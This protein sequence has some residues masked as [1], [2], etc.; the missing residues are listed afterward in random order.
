MNIQGRLQKFHFFIFLQ[1]KTFTSTQHNLKLFPILSY[2]RYFSNSNENIDHNNNFKT[3]SKLYDGHIPTHFFTKIGLAIG[4]GVIGLMNPKRDDM[5]SVLGETTGHLALKNM[6]NKMKQNDIGR[7]ILQ[8]KPLINSQTLDLNYLRNLPSNTFGKAYIEYMDSHGFNMHDRKPV[9]FVDDAELSYIMTRYRQVH[10]FLHPLSG[11]PP[12]V[13][14]ELV[15]KWY[16]LIQT[17]LPMTLFSSVIGSVLLSPSENLKFIRY[18]IPWAITAARSAVFYMNIHF[19][20]HLE[21]DIN[22]LRD[23]L[24]FVAAPKIL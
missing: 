15:L 2:F 12:T 20:K 1:Q 8:D 23:S 9:H 7:F 13:F 6:R 4:S 11:L 10:D 19:E 24:H 17:G 5:I 14:G 22:Q 21:Q 18:Y 16:E 3:S